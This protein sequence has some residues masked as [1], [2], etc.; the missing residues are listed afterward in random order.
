V[1]VAAEVAAEFAKR[2]PEKRRGGQ[3]GPVLA[4]A[5]EAAREAATEATTPL[6]AAA[7]AVMAEATSSTRDTSESSE[8]GGD[9]PMRSVSSPARL[10]EVAAAAAELE[11]A[12]QAVLNSPSSAQ[13]ASPVSAKSSKSPDAAG[14]K[15][16][17]VQTKKSSQVDLHT[18]EE[19]GLEVE[20]KPSTGAQPDSPPK[21]PDNG[22]AGHDAEA[23]QAE[24]LR[25]AA[26]LEEQRFA[27]ELADTQARKLREERDDL[28]Q[29]LRCAERAQMLSEMQVR[30]LTTE[31]TEHRRKQGD[32]K[33]STLAPPT[34]LEDV[35]KSLVTVELEQ[36]RNA[37]AEERIA[38][39]RRLL[40]RWHPD[41]NRGSGGGGSDLAT[42]VV[43]EMQGRPEWIEKT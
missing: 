40:L 20:E 1:E 32:K 25:M 43:Q 3:V 38:T 5:E 13:S 37:S 27:L 33:N 22:K 23:L 6:Q 26:E 19:E 7:D 39:K 15:A 9:S 24:V 12:A 28:A 14:E 36:L 4:A 10:I 18:L 35:V 17:G 16:R 42:R 41:K 8:L 30:T 11:A 21:V 2:T 31:V 29:R 34:T